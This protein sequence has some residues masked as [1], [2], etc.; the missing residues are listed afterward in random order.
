MCIERYM[1]VKKVTNTGDP[2]ARSSYLICVAVGDADLPD[3]PSLGL[4]ASGAH[5][6]FQR[7]RVDRRVDEVE[8]LGS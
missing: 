1:Y 4:E 6:V 7:K 3:S 2:G 8:I 5:P